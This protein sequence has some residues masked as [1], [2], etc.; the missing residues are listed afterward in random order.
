MQQPDGTFLGCGIGV[1]TLSHPIRPGIEHYPVRIELLP[2][3]HGTADLNVWL[4]AGEFHQ[5]LGGQ[6][7]VGFLW[8]RN[9]AVRQTPFGL[10]TQ[11]GC[12][13]QQQ[14]MQDGRIHAMT[15]T[16]DICTQ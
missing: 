16:A 14:Y 7:D 13:T 8:D 10:E 5:T 3:R 6:Q 1:G 4:L 15:D 2:R 12:G 11:H 9:P